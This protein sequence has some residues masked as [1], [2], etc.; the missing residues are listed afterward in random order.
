MRDKG[1]AWKLHLSGHT[2]R[3]KYWKA[4]CAGHAIIRLDPGTALP[5]IRRSKAEF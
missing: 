5:A 3:V 2:V 4:Q 1:N